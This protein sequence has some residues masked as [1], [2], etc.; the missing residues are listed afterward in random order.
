LNTLSIVRNV[1]VFGVLALSTGCIAPADGSD[2][3]EEDGPV[4]S[5]SSEIINGTIASTFMQ[6]RAVMVQSPAGACTGS[7][8]DNTHVLTAAHCLVQANLS[9]VLFYGSNSLPNGITAKVTQVQVVPGVF[10][11]SSDFTD[12]NGNWADIAV[13]TLNATIPATSVAAQLG[14]VY[15][16]SDAFGFEV[17]RGRHDGLANSSSQLR[18]A[19]NGLYSDDNSVGFFYTNDERT[20]LGDSGGPIYVNGQIQGTLSG[21]RNVALATRDEY[22]A[23]SFHLPFI[24]NAINFTGSFSSLSSGVVRTGTTIENL[25]TSDVRT[26]KLDCMQHSSCV[27]FSVRP[28]PV[29]LCTIYSSLGGTLSWPGAS[30][31]IR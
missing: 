27:A 10:P 25:A 16:G 20:N 24:L 17:G 23:V 28:T 5:A 18:F 26:C 11:F 30:T 29:N 2:G 22:T 13:L 15:P 8:I 21:T 14:I 3:A 9:T 1:S 31:G 6:Q 4:G 12:S 19:L 7:I